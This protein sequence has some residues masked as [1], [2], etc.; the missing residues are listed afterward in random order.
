ML[1]TRNRLSASRIKTFESCSYLYYAKYLAKIPDPS[2][3][4]ASIGTVVHE[5]CEILFNKQ[6]YSSLVT[7]IITTKSFP[8]SIVRIV[9][10]KL[11]K[12]KFF[13]KEAVTKCLSCLLVALENDFW[14]DGA[15]KVY[16]AEKEFLLDSERFLLYG[17]IDKYA[18]FKDS[19]G[20]WRADIRDMKSS[21]NKFTEAELDF[22]IQAISYILAVKKMHP[23]IDVL[24]SCVK[25]IMLQFPDNPLQIVRLKNESQLRGFEL[26]LEATQKKVDDFTVESRL[27]NL[28]AR[29]DFPK[30]GEGFKG[31]LLCGFAK[32][33]GQLKKDGTKMFACPYRFDFDYYVLIDTNGK[34]VE[35]SYTPIVEKNGYK[36]EKRYHAGCEAF[37]KNKIP[38]NTVNNEDDFL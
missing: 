27:S 5:V 23:E 13:S 29:Q 8:S 36:C 37:I 7:K 24:R 26:Y 6:K 17:L 16:K 4:G 18:L 22:N 15:D 19:D 14:F 28:A 38:I 21:K 30:D 3:E 20:V 11:K 2:N 12:N 25:F 9:S 31:R 35:S 33:K 1:S 34:I 10:I 32:T